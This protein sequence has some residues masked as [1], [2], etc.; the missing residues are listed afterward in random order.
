MFIL[1]FGQGPNAVYTYTYID[2]VNI[3]EFI[4]NPETAVALREK[5]I[6]NSFEAVSSVELKN[7]PKIFRSYPFFDRSSSRIAFTADG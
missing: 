7:N 2:M 3:L 6:R 1:F 4:I 5:G